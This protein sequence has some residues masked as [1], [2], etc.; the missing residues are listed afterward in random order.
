MAK[1]DLKQ[2]AAY[3]TA[4]ISFIAGWGLTIAGFVL[5]PKGEVSNSVLAV[6]GEAM[7]YAASVF[8][9]TLYFQ[10]QMAKFR[11][12]SRQYIDRQIQREQEYGQDEEDL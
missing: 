1:M 5:P 6:L 4:I 12:D 9:V 2:R 10:N 3:V 7:V 11:H 8:G